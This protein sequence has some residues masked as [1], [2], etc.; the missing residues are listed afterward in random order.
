MQA[1]EFRQPRNDLAGAVEH[2]QRQADGAAQGIDAARGVFGVLDFGE[3]F[4]RAL[5]K[6]R[7]GIRHRDAAGGAQQQRHAEAGF[8]FADD[9]RDRGLR[10]PEF[11]RRAGKTAAF[12]RAHEN[13]QF[14]QPVTHLYFK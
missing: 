3:D 1:E 11:A 5:E 13:R 4:A 10:Q 8:Q 2:R 14:L 9:A 7:A 6:Q 12:R